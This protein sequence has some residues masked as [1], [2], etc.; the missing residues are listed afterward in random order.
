MSEKNYAARCSGFV[1]RSSCPFPVAKAFDHL[2]GDI[3]GNIETTV[4]RVDVDGVRD[5]RRP[6]AR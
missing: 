5:K 1:G 6:T 3:N 4:L 2:D